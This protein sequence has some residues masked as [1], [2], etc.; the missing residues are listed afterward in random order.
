[1]S[2]FLACTL[3]SGRY[4]SGGILPTFFSS[5]IL[6]SNSN[7]FVLLYCCLRYFRTSIS[8]SHCRMHSSNLS[9]F[10]S[11]CFRLSSSSSS[12]NLSNLRLCSS[13]VLIVARYISSFF[14]FTYLSKSSFIR[15]S[16]LCF[17][18]FFTFKGTSLTGG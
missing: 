13:A 5:F 11:Y 4:A 1:M 18:S 7:S 3:R 16:R 12:F 10:F 9:F 8:K 2:L 6:L 17:I 14:Y 15:C